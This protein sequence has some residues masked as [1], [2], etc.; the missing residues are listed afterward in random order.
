MVKTMS[1]KGKL[2]VISAPS[3]CGKGTILSRLFEID[4]ENDNEFVLSISMTTRA[5]RGSEQNGVEYFFATRE[6]F[7]E[8]IDKDQFVEYA[9]FNGNYYGTPK[10]FIEKCKEEGKTVFLEIEVQGAAKVREKVPDSVSIFILPPSLEELEK[11]LRGRQTDD[12]EAIAGRLAIAPI[13]L[14]R[15][16]EFDYRVVNDDVDRASYEIYNIIKN[17]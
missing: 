7:E 11:R 13:E 16:N 5:P 10:P 8:L 12:P 15:Q 2:V 17:L 3:G 9:Q 1:D 14:A 4:K 6:E